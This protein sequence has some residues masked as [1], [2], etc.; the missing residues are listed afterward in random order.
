MKLIE[1]VR[2]I[3]LVEQAM[4]A[5]NMPDGTKIK[6][7]ISLGCWKP[8]EITLGSFPSTGI[9]PV[10]EQV[11]WPKSNLRWILLDTP[12]RKCEQCAKN[13]ALLWKHR[14]QAEISRAP[15]TWFATYTINPQSRFIFSLRS[16]SRDY[17]ASSGQIV[18]EVTK[19]FKRLRKAGYN[20]RYLYVMEAH[21]DGYP[22]VHMLIHEV[23]AQIPKRVLGTQWPYGFS[24]FK[25]V[26]DPRAAS[27]ITKYLVKDMRSKIRASQ[28]YG[29]IDTVGVDKNHGSY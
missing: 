2:F 16:G 10:V 9:G 7:D 27:Y 3:T 19:M 13:R 29:V 20:F 1:Y 15:R 5:G 18:K 8:Y 24:S 28:G 26:D 21:K 23:S 22:H 4:A 11:F 17:H 14:A 25:L 12:C 6:H